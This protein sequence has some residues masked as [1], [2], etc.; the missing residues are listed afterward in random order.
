VNAYPVPNVTGNPSGNWTDT[1]LN[2]ERQRKDSIV[3]DFVP[4]DAHHFRFSLLNYNYDDY[5]PHFGNFNTNPRIFHR[6][7]QIGVFHYT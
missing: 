3:V 5:E 4:A 1:A 6:P 7:N 2:T